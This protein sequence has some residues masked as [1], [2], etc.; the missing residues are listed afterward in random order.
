MKI[1]RVI[2]HFVFSAIKRREKCKSRLKRQLYLLTSQSQVHHTTIR[3]DNNTHSAINLSVINI[4]LCLISRY[5]PHAAQFMW[6]ARRCV[7][8]QTPRLLSNTVPTWAWL[9]LQFGCQNFRWKYRSLIFACHR[10]KA[11][12][13]PMITIS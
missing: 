12:R 8:H 4:I 11:G 7:A 3:Q 2:F 1:S 9:A 13:Y 6:T 5:H 10:S